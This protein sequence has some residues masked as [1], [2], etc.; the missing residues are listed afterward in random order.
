MTAIRLPV[1]STS[2]DRRSFVSARSRKVRV[3][4]AI[5]DKINADMN[6]VMMRPDVQKRL[7]EIGAYM[8]PM[9]RKELEG[10]I[11]QEQDQWHPLV[12]EILSKPAPAATPAAAK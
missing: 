5:V 12:R 2:T 9:S 3:P 4:D 11:K 8:I 1:P 7:I 6:K 10:F